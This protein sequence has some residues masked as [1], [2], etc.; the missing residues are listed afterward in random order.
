M[1]DFHISARNLSVRL[2]TVARDLEVESDE[3]LLFALINGVRIPLTST[4]FQVD[5]DGTLLFLWDIDGEASGLLK[6]AHAYVGRCATPGAQELSTSIA[7]Y[8]A[9]RQQGATDTIE[10]EATHG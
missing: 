8:F 1:S 6:R 5:D 3:V 9:G 10:Q 4:N 7:N 2:G